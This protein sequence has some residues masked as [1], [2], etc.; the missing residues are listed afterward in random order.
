MPIR[1]G[2]VTAWQSIQF[3]AQIFQVN[4]HFG[5]SFLFPG[6]ALGRRM[7][8]VAPGAIAQS[9]IPRD[10]SYTLGT[11]CKTWYTV[12]EIDA[13]F[14]FSGADDAWWIEP[15]RPDSSSR[16]NKVAGWL[17]GIRRYAPAR[18]VEIF[19]EVMEKIRLNNPPGSDAHVAMAMI[20]AK[21]DGTPAQ[22]VTPLAR[23][24]LH[25]KVL[26]AASRLFEGGHYRQAV[27][28]AFIAL[29][30]EVQSKSGRS[31]LDGTSLM[32]HVFSVRDP[33]LSLSDEK[34]E[35]LGNMHLFSGAILGIRN[36]R[37]HNLDDN[38]PQV[39]DE[40][41]ELLAFASFLFRQLD[42][43]QLEQIPELAE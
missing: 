8:E 20:L 34:N 15:K 43:A 19:R 39:I 42:R 14:V 27:L 21:L 17:E 37:A 24:N 3:L 33:V 16:F 28:D 22:P 9:K 5:Y 38:D 4:V 6:E 30:S 1:F 31:D 2:G 32:Q 10:L 11:V 41:L 26:A 35:Q 18:E 13:L 40:T 23:F 7:T 12:K 29:N 36:P 25:P